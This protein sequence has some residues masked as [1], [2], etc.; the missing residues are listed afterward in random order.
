M[1]STQV[2]A[3][4]VERALN[5]TS[6]NY[7][8]GLDYNFLL[9]Q[10]PIDWRVPDLSKQ[11]TQFLSMK[12]PT[13]SPAETLWV[14][15]FGMWDI[16]S[17]ATEPA[18]VSKSIIDSTMSHLFGEVERLYAS[19]M[20]NSSI[21]WSESKT[22]SST[23]T[24]TA[25]AGIS[26]ATPAPDTWIKER[27]PAEEEASKKEE[28]KAAG[29]EPPMDE[30][31]HFRILVPKLFDPSL[32]PGWK[33]ARPNVPAVHSK[34]EQMRN[35]A[36]L[37]ETWNDRL[38]SSMA[39]WIRTDERRRE[40]AKALEKAK[41]QEMVP[42]EPNHV[43]P[44]RTALDIFNE[45]LGGA[46]VEAIQGKRAGD[47]VVGGQNHLPKARTVEEGVTERE[48][49]PGGLE[50]AAEEPKPDT[51]A[52]PPL[53]QR[54]GLLYELNKYLEEVIVNRQMRNSGLRDARRFG[55]LAE[56]GFLEVWTPCV[57]EPA[58]VTRTDSAHA[59]ATAPPRGDTASLDEREEDI[60]NTAV[61]GEDTPTRRKRDLAPAIRGR[62]P[63]THVHP[64][65]PDVVEFNTCLDPDD[66]LFFTPFTVSPRA[67]AV[68]ARQAAEMVRRN[69]S[70]RLGWSSM[71]LPPLKFV[72][73]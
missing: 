21:A 30:T 46:S 15:S 58:P 63:T 71:N 8:P 67:V 69:D 22:F 36:M 32:T 39:E 2:Y 55:T 42:V 52:G 53:P 68:I 62:T 65:E 72:G 59:T 31:K 57:G 54:D 1:T 45:R 56:E 50:A 23:N 66:H 28:D 20:D 61:D 49:Q 5:L 33:S 19:A 44:V 34:A 25:S 73:R 4:S 17:L 12:K 13:H 14:F 3:T 26:M 48:T 60:P 10:F 64:A 70:V 51:I 16:W 18:D 41:A 27:D 38:W 7:G 24:S 43:M 37:T 6:E 29:M 35:A 47:V 11:I 40:K 9:D